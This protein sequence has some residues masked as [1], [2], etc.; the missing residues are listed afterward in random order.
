VIEPVEPPSLTDRVRRGAAWSTLDVMIGRTGGFALGVLVARIL[1]PADFG[2]YAVAMVVHLIVVNVSELGVTAALVN[3]TEQEIP[4]SAP[5]VATI[6]L[7]SS[8]MLGLLMAATA[9][10]FASW[11]GSSH[12][13][14][15]IQIMALTLPLAGISAVPS[16]LLRRA[17]RMDR[18][19]W[20]DTANL[21]ASAVVVVPLALAGWGPKAL[22]WSFVAG[23]LLT[24]IILLSYRPG[25][26]RP[27]WDQ[28]QARRL[29]AFGV[30]LV[31][32]NILG[33]T[34][35]NVDYIFVGR[36]LGSIDL[37]FYL[38]AFNISGWPMNVFGS[39]V[40]SVSLPAFARL[41]ERGDDMA[42]RFC[43]ALRMVSRI[44]FPVCLFLA[45]L[46][47]P[48]VQF[49]YGSKW[50][51]AAS[52]L[53]CLAIFGA[54]RTIMELFSDFLVPEGKTRALFF[55]QLAWLPALVVAL[56]VLVPKYGIVGASVAHVVVSVL[57]VIPAY[58]YAVS[59]VD[60]RPLQVARA[61]VPTLVWAGFTATI[62]WWLSTQ[63]AMPFLACLVGGGVGLAIYLIPYGG[64]IRRTLTREWARRRSSRT[65]TTEVDLAA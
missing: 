20:A 31:G 63:I 44:T 36:I 58:L 7:V 17:F 10:A 11:L 46:A 60:V 4:N 47:R 9:P 14:S 13:T 54:L 33:F 34:I 6:A 8:V 48:L 3:D 24:T 22:A 65:F 25:R 51:L 19:F 5:T 53:V 23:Q 28:G 50:G 61:L 15:T 41:K 40:R 62:A 37:G 27:G 26:Y 30:P 38:L 52:A 56:A 64:L 29:L 2:V 59:R 49:V 39:V 16:A 21:V 43:A 12:A 57:V 1:D 55:V 18:L 32:A 42:E 45:A 35:Q